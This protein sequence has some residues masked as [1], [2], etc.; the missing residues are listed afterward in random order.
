MKTK[1]ENN[2]HISCQEIG[3]SSRIFILSV[4]F[5][6]MISMVFYLLTLATT[7]PEPVNTAITS[8]TSMAMK[9]V[10]SLGEH[11]KLMWSIFFFNSLA[12]I[13]TSVGTGL[14]PYIQ[15][16]SIAEIKLRAKNQKY[17]KCSVK[18]EK[19]FSIFSFLIKNNVQ[20]LDKGIAILRAQNNYEQETSI[21]KRAKYN[22][23]N[24]RLLAYV[25]P[26]LIPITALVLNGTLLGIM[27][28]FFVFN[29]VLSAYELTGLQ[30][31]LP[32]FLFSVLYFF[33]YILPHGI[34]ELPVI[35]T[36]ASLG[37]RFA[38]I[39]SHEIVENKLFL[40]DEA[41]SIEKDILYMNRI[42]SQYI[43]SS[44]L[45]TMLSIM[46]ILLLIASYIETNVTP[47]VAQIT[48][49]IL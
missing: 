3:W 42:S 31:M 7:S 20:H 14:L 37:Y 27:L 35:I 16:I 4:Y 5:A 46:L 15:N 49:H 45:C 36:A 1:K 29:G 9:K 26:Y 38:R 48:A 2:F 11:L 22:K 12:V 44:Y 39:Y 30:G 47:T 40:G 28:S 34:I 13:T 23:E 32:G 17:S 18:L 6:F 33:A 41:E 8:G 43:R 19:T 25:V 24:F 10:E 21:W